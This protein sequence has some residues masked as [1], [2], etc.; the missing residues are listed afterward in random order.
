MKREQAILLAA[1]CMALWAWRRYGPGAGGTGT[2]ASP[3]T[4]SAAT[5]I[6]QEDDTA[7]SIRDLVNLLGQDPNRQV[8]LS[9]VGKGLDF[10]FTSRPFIERRARIPG[11]PQI[12]IP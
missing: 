5:N 1:A 9:W 11:Q 12:L 3:I 6:V 2:G 8:D 4:V 7:A 10:D